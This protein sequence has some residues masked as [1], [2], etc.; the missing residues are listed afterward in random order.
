MP[1]PSTTPRA[2]SVLQQWRPLEHDGKVL[3]EWGSSM[4]LTTAYPFIVLYLANS[5]PYLKTQL[6][7][8]LSGTLCSQITTKLPKTS[9]CITN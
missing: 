3:L 5:K 6:K 7:L 8:P 4:V 9:I 2:H 1:F